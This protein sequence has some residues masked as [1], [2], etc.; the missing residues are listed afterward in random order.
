MTDTIIVILNY[1]AVFIS[2]GDLIF[3]YFILFV[4]LNIITI[5]LKAVIRFYYLS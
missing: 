2:F 3:N 1:L 5:C 4:I